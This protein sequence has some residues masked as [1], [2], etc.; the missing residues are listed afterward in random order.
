MN[1]T[2]ISNKDIVYLH[3]HFDSGIDEP[4]RCG[5][6]RDDDKQSIARPC[7]HRAAHLRY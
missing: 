2:A 6:I 1:A 5:V 4:L 7:G 3:W